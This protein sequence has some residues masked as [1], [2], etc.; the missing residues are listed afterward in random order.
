METVEAKKKREPQFKISLKSEAMSC[1]DHWVEQLTDGRSGAKIK[2]SDVVEYVIVSQAKQ[3]TETQVR[4]FQ[5]RYVREIDVAKWAMKQLRA[6]EER[7]EQLTLIDIL[8]QKTES[9]T[10]QVSHD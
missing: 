1:I 9:T 8:T 7:G 5:S 3:L 2:A 6:A 4:E 10:K